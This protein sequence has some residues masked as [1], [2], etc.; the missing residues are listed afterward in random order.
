M[1]VLSSHKASLLPS[2]SVL[3]KVWSTG[4]GER[5]RSRRT[6]PVPRPW[7]RQSHGRRGVGNG[8]EKTVALSRLSSSACEVSVRG[9]PQRSEQSSSHKA[10]GLEGLDHKVLLGGEHVVLVGLAAVAA[11][12]EQI[13]VQPQTKLALSSPERQRIGVALDE[14]DIVTGPF[15]QLHTEQKGAKG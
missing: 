9:P 2:S 15:V 13:S 12:V 14:V 3:K 10:P 1:C 6:M 4:P 8:H 5:S 7:W 11:P